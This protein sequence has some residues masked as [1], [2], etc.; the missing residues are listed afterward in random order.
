MIS[1]FRLAVATAMVVSVSMTVTAFAA[2]V[3]LPSDESTLQELLAAVVDAFRRG[4]H[5][6]A[7]ALVIFAA[8]ALAKRYF[9]TGKVGA[10]LHGPY[11]STLVAFGLALTGSI[12][13]QD[14]LSL[15]VL[16]VSGGLAIAAVGGYTAV[17]LLIIEPIKASKYYAKAP[18]WARSAFELVLWFFDRPQDVAIAAAEKAGKDAVDAAPAGGADAVVGEA[19]KF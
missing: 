13:A 15:N 12:A 7:G 8:L 19:E 9:T 11:G 16:Y 2:G 14:S 6:A 1:R 10:F 18:A 5:V 4:H 3:V 17:K